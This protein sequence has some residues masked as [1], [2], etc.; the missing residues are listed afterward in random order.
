MYKVNDVVYLRD[1]CNSQEVRIAKS[2]VTE[3]WT[4][5]GDDVCYS[6]RG[7]PFRTFKDGHLAPDIS[8]LFGKNPRIS[9][10]LIREY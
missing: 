2:A 5:E 1:P 10:A 4:N 7:I 3:V 6:V 8:E 9:T